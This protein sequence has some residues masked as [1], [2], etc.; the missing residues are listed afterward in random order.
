MEERKWVELFLPLPCKKLGEERKF[1]LYLSEKFSFTFSSKTCSAKVLCIT[2][3]WVQCTVIIIYVKQKAFL[4]QN[5]GWL[6]F[7]G[8]SFTYVAHL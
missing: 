3:R 7:V 6:E 8:N 4:I 2:E 5:F 1:P